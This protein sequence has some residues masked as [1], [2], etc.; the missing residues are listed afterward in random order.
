M[1][2]IFYFF[3]PYKI[4]ARW[5]GSWLTCVQSFNSYLSRTS[6]LFQISTVTWAIWGIART[7]IC[8]KFV[9][10]L[11]QCRRSSEQRSFPV[12]IKILPGNLGLSVANLAKTTCL[13]TPRKAIGLHPE[14][15]SSRHQ[16]NSYYGDSPCSV[17]L[18]RRKLYEACWKGLWNMNTVFPKHW[19]AHTSPM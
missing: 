5:K 10:M 19:L 4:A 1:L 12:H 14:N 6:W 8:K 18:S 11:G 2:D 9:P 17:L 15:M 13:S 3:W 16:D 7:R